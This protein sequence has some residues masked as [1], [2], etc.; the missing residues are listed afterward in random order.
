VFL[1]LS[2]HEIVRAVLGFDKVVIIFFVHLRIRSRKARI[3]V[4]RSADVLG[5]LTLL[6]ALKEGLLD[7]SI[8]VKC[9]AHE[10]GRVREVRGIKVAWDGHRLG[11]SSAVR[12]PVLI[13]SDMTRGTRSNGRGIDKIGGGY[14]REEAFHVFNRSGGSR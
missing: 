11:M 13:W 7:G 2:M 8:L 4:L 12:L 1:E 9:T 5:R 6:H 10:I 3:D 14:L